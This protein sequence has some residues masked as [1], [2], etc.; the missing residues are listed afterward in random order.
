MAHSGRSIPRLRLY[1]QPKI[2]LKSGKLHSGDTERERWEYELTRLRDLLHVWG[3]SA[4][5]LRVLGS[6]IEML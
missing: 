3:F 5:P 6:R 1:S 2:S 4:Q